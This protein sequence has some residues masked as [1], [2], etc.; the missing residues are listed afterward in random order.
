MCPLFHALLH[1]SKPQGGA[2]KAGTCLTFI[3]LFV[4][5]N[6]F[7]IFVYCFA[8]CHMNIRVWDSSYNMLV[9]LDEICII[10]NNTCTYMKFHL[11]YAY[12]SKL[13]FIDRQE[14]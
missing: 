1:D 5:R 14:T 6:G 13:L 3:V 12:R 2:G 8:S 7:F 10:N 11:L 9:N 4:A